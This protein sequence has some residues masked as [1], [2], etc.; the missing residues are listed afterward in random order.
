MKRI[1]KTESKGITV[2]GSQVA[3]SADLG[4]Q[5]LNNKIKID[6]EKKVETPTETALQQPAV[7]RSFSLEEMKKAFKAGQE[8]I[9]E[10]LEQTTRCAKF[11]SFEEWFENYA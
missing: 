5:M 8:T 7:M 3:V 1:L 6:M 2:I 4:V 11:E 9:W 10:D